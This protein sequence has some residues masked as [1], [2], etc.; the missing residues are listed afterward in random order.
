MFAFYD[1]FIIWLFDVNIDRIDNINF[2]LVIKPWA[3]N[4]H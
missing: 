3:K 4:K 2:M 1:H